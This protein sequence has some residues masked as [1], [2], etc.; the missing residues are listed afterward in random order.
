[1]K[2]LLNT[3]ALFYCGFSCPLIAQE[4]TKD[5]FLLSD[6]LKVFLIQ[7][8]ELSESN[9][10]SF[11]Y[12]PTNL[13]LSTNEKKQ[14]EFLLMLYRNGEDLGGIMHWI[15]TWGLTDKQQKEIDTLILSKIDSSARVLGSVMVDAD[16]K[17]EFIVK[18]GDETWIPF[19]KKNLTSGGIIPTMAGSKGATSFKFGGS[20]VEKLK[21]AVKNP[22]ILRGVYISMGFDYTKMEKKGFISQGVKKRINLLL[23]VETLFR[24][25]K[26]CKECIVGLE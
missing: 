12:L 17:Y 18:G 16:S 19:L 23:S 20:D 21:T 9:G 15:L 24:E 26:K 3:L 5:S 11:H 2:K 6:S 4:A 14:P 13:R 22:K 7:T 10:K 1:M 25:A 8:E